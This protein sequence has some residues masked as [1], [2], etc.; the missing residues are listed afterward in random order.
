MLTTMKAAGVMRAP[1]PSSLQNACGGHLRRGRILPRVGAEGNQGD[2][3]GAVETKLGSDGADAAIDVE[4]QVS[5]PEPALD[6][7]LSQFGQDHRAQE[8]QANLASVV[9]PLS[10]RPTA[11]PA[12]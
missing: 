7:L 8:R 3:W 12:G 2:L 10:M 9:W 1:L 11:L 5:E 4:L 6:I